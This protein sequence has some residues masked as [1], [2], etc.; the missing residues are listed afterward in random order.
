M[1]EE[2]VAIGRDTTPMSILL[3]AARV[4]LTLGDR[5]AAR[6]H[7]IDVTGLA[8]QRGDLPACAAGKELQA[9]VADDPSDAARLVAEA[10]AIWDVI[11]SPYG[12][13]R[14]RLIAARVLT[15]EAARTAAREAEAGFRALGARGP[16]SEAAALLDELDRAT[17]PPLTIQALGRFRVLRDGEPVPATAWQSKKARDLLKI[18]VARRG[19]PTTRETFF[20]LLWP[21]ED[22]GPLSNRLSVALA[23]VRGVLD[24]DRRYPAE[25]FLAADKT[26]ISLDLDH[27]DL[28]VE[29]FR[30]EAAAGARLLRSGDRVAA[31]ARFESAEALYAGDFLEEDPYEDWAVGLREEAQATYIAVARTLAGA[32]AERGDAD[33]ATRFY[34]RILERDAYDE[35]AHLGL[36]SALLAAGRHGEAR[37]RYGFY[38]TKMAEIAVEA[39]PIPTVRREDSAGAVALPAG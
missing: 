33:G 11:P 36:V 13:A 6:S 16:A 38:A 14:N 3:G 20:E 26:A 39:A 25:H 17:R 18:V 9:L 7:A 21:D 35:G 8:E 23:T 24:P 19:R 37:R 12:E 28:D 29:R 4:A 2:A 10:A 32:A 15:G 5:E 34:L 27:V 22:P 30:V 31:I 1:A